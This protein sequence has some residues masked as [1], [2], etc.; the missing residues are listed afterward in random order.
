MDKYTKL[1]CVK[2]LIMSMDEQL[3]IHFQKDSLTGHIQKTIVDKYYDA[4]LEQL[5]QSEDEKKKKLIL[6]LH[7]RGIISENVKNDLLYPKHENIGDETPE[8][9]FNIIVNGRKHVI[10]TPEENQTIDWEKIILLSELAKTG[11]E[12]LIVTYTDGVDEQTEGL[13]DLGKSVKVKEG[14]VFNV[15][16][17]LKGE[18]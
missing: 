17:T 2:G 5:E 7:K 6:A 1:M 14:M 3:N 8:W 12:L 11:E 16:N 18:R 15:C 9:A 10:H 13:L 4:I